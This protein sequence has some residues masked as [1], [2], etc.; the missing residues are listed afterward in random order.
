MAALS[1]YTTPQKPKENPWIDKP[2]P[3]TP[4]N[5]ETESTTKPEPSPESNVSALGPTEIEEPPVQARPKRRPPSRRIMRHVLRARAEAVRALAGFFE[6]LEKESVAGEKRVRA[7]VH[8]VRAYGGWVDGKA[9]QG[10]R[11]ETG[12]AVESEAG[13]QGWRSAAE[14]LGFLRARGAKIPS[15]EGRIEGEWAALSSEEPV[16]PEE[17]EAGAEKD[18]GNASSWV[19]L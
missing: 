6:Q 11:Q 9:W 16:S 3:N 8:L 2:K 13:P 19:T 7:S 14:V 4:P 15:L 12:D 17:G 5:I 18:D 1:Q 10:R